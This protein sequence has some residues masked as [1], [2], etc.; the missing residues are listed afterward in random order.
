MYMYMYITFIKIDVAQAPTVDFTDT[1]TVD[2]N[3]Y[4]SKSNFEKNGSRNELKLI[5]GQ[6]QPVSNAYDLT[7]ILFRS[8]G[9]IVHIYLYMRLSNIKLF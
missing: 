9:L 8:T 3:T 5:T 6:L 4:K 2:K 1:T 7:Y